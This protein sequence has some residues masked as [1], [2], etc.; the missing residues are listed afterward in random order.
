MMMR[1]INKGIKLLLLTLT[2]V[3]L[4]AV[5]SFA[6][7]Y[8]LCA[9]SVDMTMP[10]ATVVPMWGFALDDNASLA[11]GCPADT[12]SVPGPKLTVPVGDNQLIINPE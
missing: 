4:M 7:E 5:P 8:Y 6:V 10:D 11:D 3:S 1:Y 2:A 12:A 9:Q